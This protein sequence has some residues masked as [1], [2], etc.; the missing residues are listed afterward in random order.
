MPCRC[1]WRGPF[2]VGESLQSRAWA[3]AALQHLC[4]C[5]VS[6]D[7]VCAGALQHS[8]PPG[9]GPKTAAELAQATGG[10]LVM[11]VTHT[12]A[13]AGSLSKRR[14]MRAHRAAR[15][16]RMQSQLEMDE[17]Q[18]HMN[19]P[20][21]DISCCCCF[22][23]IRLITI[24]F[25]WPAAS[26]HH[27]FITRLHGWRRRDIIPRIA[28][29]RQ[30]EITTAAAAAVAACCLFTTGRAASGGTVAELAY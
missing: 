15:L 11:H 24:S 28:L 1:L 14:H 21:R 3:S 8:G 13:E 30:G 7:S 6:T 27:E 9:V 29:Q 4:V 5:R 10:S 26:S 2:L 16:R 23:H 22:K 17:T 20:L 25:L 18:G 12:S 19:L